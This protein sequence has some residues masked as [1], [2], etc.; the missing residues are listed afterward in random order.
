MRGT[1]AEDG[2]EP[3]LP[4]GLLAGTRNRSEEGMSLEVEAVIDTGFDGE[5]TL[6]SGTIRR[7]GYPYAGSAGGILAD[8]REIQF[9][10]HEA[11]VLWHGM[12]RPVAVIAAEGQPLI[13]MALLRGSRLSVEDLPGGRVAVSEL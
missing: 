7:L 13:G 1:V 11:R 12:V 4:L 6:T 2:S 8:G 9:D 10:Y 5:L 3:L